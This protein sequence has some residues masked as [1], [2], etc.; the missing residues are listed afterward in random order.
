MTGIK[1]LTTTEIYRNK[2]MRLRE[3]RILRADGNEGST[4]WL[5]KPILW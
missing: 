1:T 3:D 4:R 2:W 5:R